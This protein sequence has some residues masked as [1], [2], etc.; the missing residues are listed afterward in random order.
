MKP[1]FQA[2]F[3]QYLNSTRKQ[4]EGFTLIELLVVIIIIG[5]LAAI[6]LPSLL[7]QAN[8]AKQSEARNNVGSIARGMQ[9]YQLEAGSFSTD[10][11]KLGLGLKTQTVN[12]TYVIKKETATPLGADGAA[13]D[14][15]R[16]V[17]IY[18]FP[19][20]QALKGYVAIAATGYSDIN[21]IESAEVTTQ[22]AVCESKKA[23]NGNDAWT[24]EAPKQD[25]N[26]VINCTSQTGM[27]GGDGSGVKGWK[28]LGA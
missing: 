20:V 5:I 3:L 6:A 24:F 25:N 13:Q 11:V 15:W 27:N 21:N 22:I 7:G 19:R 18:A 26:G 17:N 2:K 4:D 16:N 12:Y 23:W 28:D 1:E 10:I 8:K 14:K 9:A